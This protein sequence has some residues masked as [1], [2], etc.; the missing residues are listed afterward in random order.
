METN[1]NW[2]KNGSNSYLFVNGVTV[3]QFKEEASKLIHYPMCFGN[4]SKDF[5]VNYLKQIRLNGYE[6]DFSIDIWSIDVVVF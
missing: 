6:Y 3:F 2:H 5:S 4:I 1:L